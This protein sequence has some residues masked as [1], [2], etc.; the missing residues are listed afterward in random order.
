MG[1]YIPVITK[2][3]SRKVR[4]DDIVYLEQRQRKV[5]IVTREATY[6]CYEKISN[7][8]KQLDERFYHTLKKLVVNLEQISAMRDQNVVFQ[9]GTVL[10]LGRESY[11]RTKQVYTAYLRKLI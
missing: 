7:I 2:E 6:E 1:E 11:I 5:G 3:C 8:E 4:V 9:N 10:M